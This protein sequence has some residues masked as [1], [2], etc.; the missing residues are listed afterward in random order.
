MEKTEL[1]QNIVNNRNKNR[2]VFSF[3][4]R[5]TYQISFYFKT[6]S[7]GTLEFSLPIN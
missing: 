4:I 7:E 2:N 1:L 5:G 3:K 6:F